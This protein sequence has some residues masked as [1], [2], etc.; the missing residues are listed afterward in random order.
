VALLSLIVSAATQLAAQGHTT[1]A[2][3]HPPRTAA[4]PANPPA[5]PS[6]GTVDSA[7]AA[8]V[9]TGLQAQGALGP[10]IYYTVYGGTYIGTGY[11]EYPGG[12][13]V[14]Q[15][16]PPPNAEVMT[17]MPASAMAWVPGRWQWNGAQYYWNDGK[18]VSIPGGYTAW[19]PGRWAGN[20]LGYYW[21]P[22]HWQR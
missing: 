11:S 2:P 18:W 15:A 20:S 6:R 17:P 22:G 21:V 4:Q 14:D 5:Q 13:Y 16:P 1:A 10:V 8:G 19:V 3:R 9:V 7:F 12:T